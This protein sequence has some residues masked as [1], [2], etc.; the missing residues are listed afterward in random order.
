[1]I[2]TPSKGFTL[3]E[4]LVVIA[5]IAVLAAILFPVFARA[6]EKARQSTCTSNQ[7]Q[8]AV[9]VL[10]YAQDHEETLPSATDWTNAAGVAD[11]KIFDCPTSSTA[12][13]PGSSDYLYLG[14]LNSVT[15][16]EGL[17]SGL[18]IGAY[19]DPAGTPMFFDKAAGYPAS[20]VTFTDPD[21]YLYIDKDVYN[22]V[23]FRHNNS[24]VMTFL[25]GHVEVKVKPVVD[26]YLLMRSKTN[27]DFVVANPT[28]ILKSTSGTSSYTQTGLELLWNYQNIKNLYYGK[29]SGFTNGWYTSKGGANQPSWISGMSLVKTDGVTGSNS[30]CTIL[31]SGFGETSIWWN[32][33][34]KFTTIFGRTGGGGQ[35][36]QSARL[37]ITPASNLVTMKKLCVST[38][39]DPEGWANGKDNGTTVTVSGYSPLSF[40]LP[41]TNFAK[42]TTYYSI[43][44]VPVITGKPID[45]D[46]KMSC[47]GMGM[48]VS[49][50][51]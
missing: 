44:L 23:D 3:I 25:D 19:T 11:S 20:Y 41:T 15:N 36:A 35:V 4:L 8:L 39:L 49:F 27:R 26:V 2:R 9:A 5:I 17:L 45:I 32:V 14:A 12:G 13:S 46:M 30:D 29:R 28:I 18:T 42:N 43:A 40:G 33:T 7:R 24:V 1:M 22:A 34:S 48:A 37:T 31:P 47:Y 50:E 38:A 10:M 6:R 21:N 51:D 16:K